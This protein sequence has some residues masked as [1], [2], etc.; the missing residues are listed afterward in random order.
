MNAN[1]TAPA[2]SAAS[3]DALIA[4]AARHFDSGAYTLELARRVAARTESQ[5]PERHDELLAYLTGDTAAC[6]AA[7]GFKSEIWENPVDGAP[8]FLFASRIEHPE[9]PTVL[10]YGH[11]DVVRGDDA[12]WAPGLEPWRVQVVGDRLYGRGTADNKGQHSVNLAA[13]ALTLQARGGKLGFNLKCLMEMGEEVGSPGLAEVAALH[14]AELRA[15]RF[16]A[17]DGPRVDAATPTLFLGSRGFINFTLSIESRQRS[18]HSGNWGGLLANPA[19]RL[20]NALATL[21]D[22][23]GAIRLAG[24]KPAS[25][26]PEVRARLADVTLDDQPGAPAID[27]GWGEPGLSRSEKLYGWNAFEVLAMTAGNPAAPVNAIPPSARAHCQLRF[28]VGTDWARLDA[29]LRAHFDSLGFPDVQVAL[30][31]R[32]PATRLSPDDPW[33]RFVERSV[34]ATLGRAPRVLPNIGGSIPN[35]VFS[36]VLGL[37][38]VWMPHSYPGCAQHAP[39]EHMLANVAREGLMMMAGVWWDLG[40]RSVAR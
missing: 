39:D 37:P 29:L 30:G 20:A 15:D 21:A 23:R 4:A 7:L 27:D 36:D 22:E 17:S 18:Y 38:T 26:P 5:N 28:V 32:S 3:R 19:L 1:F 34:E 12:N 10:I 33:V 9:L 11:G 25:L 35:H 13:L 14:A 6:L 16:L 8:P 2:S 24:L 31:D 40:E